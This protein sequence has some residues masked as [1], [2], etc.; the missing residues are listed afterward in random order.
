MG[1]V[2]INRE[3]AIYQVFFLV[4]KKLA[5]ESSVSKPFQFSQLC[6]V[7]MIVLCTLVVNV[8]VSVL[9]LAVHIM[10]ML[11]GMCMSVSMGMSYSVMGMLMGV[12]MGML[13]YVFHGKGLLCA[14][15][16]AI[17]A[18]LYIKSI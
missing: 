17:I 10:H 14:R 3:K 5:A 12:F 18:R 7:N 9:M 11:V 16:S 1:K 13:V 4:I 15:I 2:R 8:V 6:G